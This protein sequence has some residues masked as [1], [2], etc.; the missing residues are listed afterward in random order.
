MITAIIIDDEEKNIA[1]LTSLLNSYCP[2]IKLAGT[3]CN[4]KDGK[5]L[6]ET[7][8]PDVIFLDIEMP[9][10]SG[11][12]LLRSLPEISSEIIFITAFD[13]YALTAFRYAAIDYL[14]KPVNIEQLQEAVNR[15]EQN[16]SKRALENN[17]RLLL[18]NLDE[19]DTLKREIA[20][21]DKGC[22]FYIGIADI[23][24]II[25]DGSYTHVHTTSRV[26]VTTKNLKDFEEILPPEI[27]CR[28]HHG[29]MI[30]RQH[31]LKIEKGRGG[32]VHM[33]DNAKLEIAVRKK[34]M[35]MAMMK[36]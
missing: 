30:N 28:I 6:I 23:K 13:Q 11:F 14:L 12:D 34:E 10:G 22:Q 5:K 3:A 36:K 24:Y 31:I 27:F 29:H 26:F 20:I 32:F 8:C 25:A 19:S 9:Y 33:S 7:C 15:A 35:F 1:M 21:T 17:Y 2:Q 4:I 16:V 18:R